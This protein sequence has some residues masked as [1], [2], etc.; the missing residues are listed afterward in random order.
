MFSEAD[1]PPILRRFKVITSAELGPAPPR[2]EDAGGEEAG[3]LTQELLQVK[4]KYILLAPELLACTVQKVFVFYINLF[5]Q[6]L[7][8]EGQQQQQQ[9]PENVLQ[10]RNV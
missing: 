4:K 2:Q 7:D 9:Q 1:L 5:N 6:E 10:V 8:G 3:N